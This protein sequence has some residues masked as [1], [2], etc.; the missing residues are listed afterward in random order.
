[1]KAEERTIS[2]IL[3]EQICYEIPPYQ[4]PYSW[5]VDNVQQLLEDTWEAFSDNDAEYFVG[6]LITIERQK[7]RLYDVVDGQ[8][9]LTTLNVILAKIRD[10]IMDEG[11]KADLQKRILP[12]NVYT[13]EAETPR[14]VLRRRDQGFFRKHILESAALAEKARA[15]LQPKDPQL[16]LV[17]NSEA[18][19]AFCSDKTQEQLKLFAN[20]LLSKVYVVFVT[21][22]SWQS[23]YRLFNV[24][25]ARGIPLSNADLIKN[26]LFG[27]LENAAS[28]SDDLEEKWLE[29][30]EELGIERMDA[31]FGH[32]RTSV[33]AAKARG[34]LYE[35]FEPLVKAET[36]GPLV[37][38]DAILASAENYMRIL[39]GDFSDASAS[40][41]LRALRRVEYDEWIPPLLAYLNRPVDGLGE[42]E[43][44]GL[45]ERITMQ[46][47]V[48][49]LGRAARQTVYF[50]LI[51]AIRDGK[52]A[53][54]VQEIFRK[55]A[56]NEE[57]LSLLGGEVYGRQFDGAVL[58]RLEE[59]S[60][61][62]SVTKSYSG[63]LTIEH[64]L[65]QALKDEYWK[66]RFTPELQAVWLHR[67]GNL[68]LLCGHKNYKAQYY[69]FERKKD[70]Y[71]KRN[72]KVSF[73]L[74][75]EVCEHQE[76]TA[77]AIEDRQAKLMDLARTIWMIS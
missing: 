39:E 55:N 17:E 56:N 38:L 22:Q 63:R 69:D 32:H 26:A 27:Q 41:S 52:D 21:T 54:A 74:T 6:S 10:A 23:A 1:M 58:L 73:D 11:V 18:V 35:E 29:L 25:N 16:R 14:L 40:R 57:F 53:A 36:G 61:D 9:R 2:N 8:Q 49:R 37:F 31:F 13:G 60:Q 77:K 65:P 24:L 68:T 62:D 66:T 47:W 7:D 15:E 46:N 59:A 70:I 43:F 12:K 51:A 71:N 67:L 44:I 30:E 42:A 5:G 50:Q 28:G 34:T 75:K 20:F 72:K 45:L 3:T 19:D 76:W 64:I 4:R 33:V 48:R